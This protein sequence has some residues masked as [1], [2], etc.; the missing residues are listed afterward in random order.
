MTEGE[1]AGSNRLGRRGRGIRNRARDIFQPLFIPSPM[2]QNSAPFRY[3]EREL[4]ECQSLSYKRGFT[5]LLLQ[6]WVRE[7]YLIDTSPKEEEDDDGREDSFHANFS[8]VVH[9]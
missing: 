1:R 4:A 8:L 2:N 3:N 9:L 7:R 6:F 5:V